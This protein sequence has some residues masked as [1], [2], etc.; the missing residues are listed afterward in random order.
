MPADIVTKT[1]I[2]TKLVAAKVEVKP[3]LAVAT[4]WAQIPGLRCTQL[5]RTVNGIDSA[6]LYYAAGHSVAQI[7]ETY[8]ECP[9]LNI[10][11]QFIRITIGKDTDPKQEVWVGKLV[12]DHVTRAGVFVAEG[13]RR[14]RAQDQTFL[15]LGLAHLLDSRQVDGAVVEPTTRIGRPLIFNSQSNA[16]LASN[17]RR[18][19]NRATDLNTDSVYPFA[20]VP[21]GTRWSAA[22]IVKYLLKYFAPQKA[23]GDPFPTELVL[24]GDSATLLA[25]YKP[26]LD[27]G[28]KTTH[29]LLNDLLNPQRGF[30]WSIEYSELFGTNGQAIVY[31]HSLAVEEATLPSDAT[32]PAN[33]NQQSLDFDLDETAS[34]PKVIR[35]DRRRY[36]RVRARGAPITATFTIGDGDDTKANDWT[37]TLETTYKNGGKPTTAGPAL[38]AYNALTDDEKA[39]KNDAVRRREVLERVYAAFRIPDDWDKKSGD[40]GAASPAVPRNWT[41]ADT[42][43]TGSILGSLPVVVG[44]IRVLPRTLL[45][46]GV[47]YSNP[48]SLV[49]HNP[50]GSEPDLVP[51]FAAVKVATDPDKWHFA[52]KLS[53]IDTTGSTPEGEVTTSYHLHAQQ[54]APGV[55][56]KAYS[57]SA[58]TLAKNHW[59][60]AEPT[61]RDPEL[62][63]TAMIITR[64]A[65][66]DTRVEGAWPASPPADVMLEELVLDLGNDY[67][68]D[69]L[70]ENTVVD[71]VG[72]QLVK[73]EASSNVGRLLRDD[74]EALE[75]IARIA[76]EWYQTERAGLELTLRQTRK[77]FDLGMMVTTI[78]DDETL[79]TINSVI[80][81]VVYD[82]M[83]GTQTI[84]TID[85]PIDLA[86]IVS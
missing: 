25:G 37:S 13:Q 69:F 38:D 42:E 76:F 1:V 22:D 14:F 7:G 64:A 72:S 32:L 17:R 27:P 55:V 70:P 80:G 44:N 75:D 43:K 66:A 54:H 41:F 24:D 83:Q 53:T 10:K 12:D 49:D 81:T 86:A 73:A 82:M 67:R 36:N 68:L 21:S 60:G 33:T 20:K 50:S 48:S 57:G 58:H 4:A 31:A 9:P 85:N 51:P 15:A 3:T 35:N 5:T 78:G 56:V 26:T 23:G 18:L 29:E 45:R 47:D 19:G 79:E 40:G 30:C 62:D 84:A 61:A 11:G 39:A 34:P 77:L 59:S 52:D 65:E 2:H 6:M 46:R 28:T 63:Y 71:I 8:D 74:R 16:S